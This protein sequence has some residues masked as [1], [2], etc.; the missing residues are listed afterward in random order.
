MTKEQTLQK[1]E[2]EL[3]EWNSRGTMK[4]VSVHQYGDSKV[5]RYEETSIPDI[6]PDEVLIRCTLQ[7]LIRSTGKSAKGT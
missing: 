4:T 5:L 3:L 7:G 6:H 2:A 1:E